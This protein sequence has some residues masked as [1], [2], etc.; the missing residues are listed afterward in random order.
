MFLSVITDTTVVGNPIYRSNRASR[1]RV[2][3]NSFPCIFFD[4]ERNINKGVV[5]NKVRVL[6]CTLNLAEA[7]VNNNMTG[8]EI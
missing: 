6:S 5:H 7:D 8:K 2:I 3:R 1:N 4:P